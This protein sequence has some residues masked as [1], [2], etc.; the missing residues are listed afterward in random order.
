MVIKDFSARANNNNGRGCCFAAKLFH[1]FGGG[2]GEGT[3]PPKEGERRI[4]GKNVPI[5]SV[6]FEKIPIDG[7]S[8]LIYSSSILSLEITSRR[9]REYLF[10]IL[11][12]FFCPLVVVVPR[13][14]G[15]HDCGRRCGASG[16]IFGH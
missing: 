13:I 15:G 3:L 2:I 4:K 8:L 6:L 7:K 1:Y 12:L 11:F 14:R 9:H 10:I 5:I 16:A